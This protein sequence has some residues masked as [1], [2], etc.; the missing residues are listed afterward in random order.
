MGVIRGVCASC[1][2]LGG[3]WRRMQFRPRQVPRLSLPARAGLPALA[4]AGLLFLAS[5]LLLV[6]GCATFRP[7][8]YSSF[9]TSTPLPPRNY[10]VLGFM[11]AREGWDAPRRPV[12]ILALE[13]RAMNLPGVHVET[14]ENT[15]RDLALQFVRSALDRNGDGTLDAQERASTGII[16]YGHSFGAA[17][18][19]KFAR[20]L[21]KLGVPVLLTVQVDSVGANDSL[22]PANVA[23]AANFYQGAGLFIRGQSLI[24]PE[25]PEKTKIVGNFEYDTN[26]KQ[27]VPIDTS[28]FPWTGRVFARA[29]VKMASDPAVWKRVEALIL[30]EVGERPPPVASTHAAGQG[31]K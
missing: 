3:N 4:L 9:I 30:D 13:L 16:L 14:V 29:H 26:S 31:P 21:E 15:R 23:R 12:R 28:G 6:S 11:G 27:A 5:I 18:V 17:A 22:I 24:R 1:Q 25:S 19:V 20:Q 2:A 10:L 7:Q 8:T